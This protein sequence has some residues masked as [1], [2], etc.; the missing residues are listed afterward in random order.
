[1]A[2]SEIDLTGAV[3]TAA[4][5]DARPV[6]P[7][8]D[9]AALFDRIA[10]DR[11]R[12]RRNLLRPVAM[13]GAAVVVALVA[14]VTWPHPGALATTPP[15]PDFALVR[16]G[17]V[18]A[19]PGRDARDLLLDLAAAAET[20]ADPTPDTV[21]VVETDSWFIDLEASEAAGDLALRPTR[22][23]AWRYPDGAL[24]REEHRDP[25]RDAAGDPVLGDVLP[26]HRASTWTIDYLPP[27]TASPA[28]VPA[29]PADPADLRATLLAGSDCGGPTTTT[30]WCRF[31]LLDVVAQVPAT[32]VVPG[33]VDAALWRMLAA[34]PGLVTLGETR[35]R[36][37]RDGVSITARDEASGVMIVLLADPVDGRLLGT[38]RILLTDQPEQGLVAPVVVSFTTYLGSRWEG[39][40]A[41]PTVDPR[42]VCEEHPR[43]RFCLLPPD[44]T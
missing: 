11:T 3:V 15:V 13:V 44:Q 12:P 26:A 6:A 37:G 18:A 29:L 35:D 41:G 20:R 30:D 4:G 39:P 8:A 14:V 27:D 10:A 32:E 24:T 31:L 28:E 21:Q 43:I 16:G 2:S 42:M 34:E 5:L 7:P 9:P 19:A 23:T 38:E 17:D 1:M 25:L 36:A 40:D 22:A 33:A